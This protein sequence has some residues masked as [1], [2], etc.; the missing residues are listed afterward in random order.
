MSSVCFGTV[1]LDTPDPRGL[2]AFYGTLLGWEV[3]DSSDD[4][5]VTIS[6][7]GV[8][9]SFQLAPDH[10]PPTWPTGAVPQQAH[11]DLHVADYASTE[12]QVLALGGR[13]LED[14]AEHPSWRVYAD[15]SGHPF[16]L[17][18]EG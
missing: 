15:P 17:C 16:C 6:G 2:A 18:L 7:G 14:D 11:V 12:P 3:E 5:W 1:A 10:V 4:E 9:L 13:L 8:R